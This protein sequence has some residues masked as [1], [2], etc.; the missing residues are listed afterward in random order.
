MVVWKSVR[1][2]EEQY[3]LISTVQ[4]RLQQ[5]SLGKVSF[6]QALQHI[7]NTSSITIGELQ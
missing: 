3:D 7:I 4:D 1:V 5:D 6:P 2:P